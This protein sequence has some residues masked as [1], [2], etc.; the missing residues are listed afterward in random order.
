MLKKMKFAIHLINH[1]D[2]HHQ[3]LTEIAETVEA[4][5]WELN[6]DCVLT[7]DL[8]LTDRQYI[9]LG[10]N[11]LCFE[12][13]QLPSNSI[14]YNL[15]QIYT[16]SP[17][18]KAGYIDYLYQY[19]IWDYSQANIAQ[20]KQLGID[21][22]QYLPVGY[23]S[24]MNRISL[25]RDQDIDILFYGS[26]NQ[27][28]Q[29]IIEALEEKGAKVEALF[30]VYNQERDDYIARAK[31]V[32][33][34]H[35]YD[36]QVFEVV[37]VSYLLANQVFVISEK[38]CDGEDEQYFAEGLVFTDYNKLVDTCLDYLTKNK[39]REKIAKQGFK[40]IKNRPA[41]QYL[42]AVISSIS[43][44]HYQPTSFIK[45][46]YRKRLAKNYLEHGQYQQAI[47]LYEQSLQVDP[48]CSTSY[49]YLGLALLFEGDELASQLT[50][51]S[52][53][54]HG[55]EIGK[56]SEQITAEL[57]QFLQQEQQKQ[58]KLNNIELANKITTSIQEIVS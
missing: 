10:A 57:L 43:S 24:Q 46:F 51:A 45:D 8:S 2:G 18:L 25:N 27:R 31:I 52:G 55:Q 20:L 23:V 19:P 28:R 35:F 41:S 17:W 48:D 58:L 4:G 12:P 1:P 11:A 37:R 3:C 26:I 14:I 6:Y 54:S 15:E 38:G 9:I 42:K 22:V 39:Q 53:I 56:N 30:G 44:E 36:A 34:M 47:K 33:N 13:I 7:N 49:W 21:N 50:W 29:K 5:L 16:D 32:L 40:L